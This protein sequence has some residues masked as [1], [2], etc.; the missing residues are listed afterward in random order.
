[1][2]GFLLVDIIPKNFGLYMSIQFTDY[3]LGHCW[4]DFSLLITVRTVWY[5]CGTVL[6]Y[7]T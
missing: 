4:L 7:C 3:V 2:P 6:F 5:C 1:M